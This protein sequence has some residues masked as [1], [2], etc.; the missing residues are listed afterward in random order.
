M[1]R[2][3]LDGVSLGFGLV[4][5]VVGTVFL[6]SEVDVTRVSW[7]WVTPAAAIV[8]GA[9]ILA[10]TLRRL[11]SPPRDSANGEPQ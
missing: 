10:A 4:F 11:T 9:A 3:E 6:V 8:A 1:W 5:A 7:E 2:H